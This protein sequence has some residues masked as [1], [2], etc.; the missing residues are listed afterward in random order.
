[1]ITLLD[2]L[3]KPNCVEVIHADIVGV[4]SL[5]ESLSALVK[6]RFFVCLLAVRRPGDS[7]SYVTASPPA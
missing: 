3:D 2:S 4:W 1:M 7:S 6:D 5:L